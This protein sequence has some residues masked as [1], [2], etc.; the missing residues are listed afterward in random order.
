MSKIIS[1][2]LDITVDNL[3]INRSTVNSGGEINVSIGNTS[4]DICN[5]NSNV[6]INNRFILNNRFN[7]G[8][9]VVIGPTKRSNTLHSGYTI[10]EPDYVIPN[11]FYYSSQASDA[12]DG[13]ADDPIVLD[14]GIPNYNQLQ[15]TTIFNSCYNTTS[16]N[17]TIRGTTRVATGGINVRMPNGSLNAGFV[18]D[19]GGWA[20][21]INTDDTW[22]IVCYYGVYAYRSDIPILGTSVGAGR[23][24]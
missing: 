1:S 20:S 7:L 4:A 19:F 10:P 21:L 17:D 11:C 6:N 23:W 22:V 14:I 18:L 24:E 12:P 3:S 5:F 2:T 8:K 13:L 9:L 16:G 15:V